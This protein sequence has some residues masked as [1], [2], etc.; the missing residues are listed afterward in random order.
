MKI[1]A[2]PLDQLSDWGLSPE[3]IV[4]WGK[5]PSNLRSQQQGTLIEIV[6]RLRNGVAH[7][8]VRALGDGNE[9]SKLEFTDQNGFCAVFPVDSLKRFVTKLAALVKP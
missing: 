5:H 3:F 1:P 2:L 9:I 6:Q 8:H 4:N 7:T